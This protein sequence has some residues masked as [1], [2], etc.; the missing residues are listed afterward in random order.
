[1]SRTVNS[2]TNAVFDCKY[3]V[4]FCSKYRRKVLWIGYTCA[5]I[6][7]KFVHFPN[8]YVE[9]AER[10]ATLTSVGS[11]QSMWAWSKRKQE[12]FN[13]IEHHIELFADVC[14]ARADWM[15][16]YG[17]FQEAVGSDQ[18]DHAIFVLEAAERNYQIQLRRA[19][20]SG[21]HR[22]RLPC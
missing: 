8:K 7:S 15:R 20:Q 12:Q 1:M 17:M 14:A 5:D 4:V 2:N 13:N 3:H 21:L 22:L 19:K 16:A 9:T 18:I 10:M 6:G 11:E